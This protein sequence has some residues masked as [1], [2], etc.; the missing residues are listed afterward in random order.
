MG[1]CEIDDLKI[2]SDNTEYGIRYQPTPARIFRKVIRSL[3]IPYEEFTF[4]DFGSGKGRTLLLASE[5]PFKSVIGIE[6]A[7][8]L[9][10][11]AESNIRSFRARQQCRHIQSLCI[12]AAQYMP[13]CG[14]CVLY[15]Y[16]PF[17]EPVMRAVMGA[18]C[19]ARAASNSDVIIVNYEPHP[20]IA[21]L[22]DAEAS[23]RSVAETREY[24]IYRSMSFSGA[25]QRC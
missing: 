16:F 13:P 25:F 24:T 21:R 2:P 4:V 1:I 10:K 17:Q 6:F 15:F 14:N 23:F 20:A 18:I 7:P 11:I 12:D 9:H 3:E 5:F 8:E 22:L 19:R